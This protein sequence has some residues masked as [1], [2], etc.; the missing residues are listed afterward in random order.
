[1]ARKLKLKG[2]GGHQVHSRG[3]KRP[4]G[5]GRTKERGWKPNAK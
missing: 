4:R 5:K 1:M 3:A 2:V